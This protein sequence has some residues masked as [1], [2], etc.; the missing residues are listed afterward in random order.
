MFLNY[1]LMGDTLLS[2]V[3]RKLICL[4]QVLRELEKIVNN[5]TAQ[6]PHRNNSQYEKEK[7]NDEQRNA[8]L[9]PILYLIKSLW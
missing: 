4:R 8:E 7:E 6:G 9:K 2:K 3:W 1:L 5:I